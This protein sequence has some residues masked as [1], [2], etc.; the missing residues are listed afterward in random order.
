[1][2]TTKG[3]SNKF[4]DHSDYVM[5]IQSLV[6]ELKRPI[7]ACWVKGTPRRGSS[8]QRTI[9]RGSTERRCGQTGHATIENIHLNPPMRNIDHI[10]CQK[11]SLTINGQRYPLNWDT[12]VRW[13]INGTYLKQYLTTKH[14]WSEKTWRLI[15]PRLVK[16]YHNHKMIL[17]R[18]MWFKVAH[19]L[20][21]LGARKQKM[22]TNTCPNINIDTCPCCQKQPETQAT[23]HVHMRIQSE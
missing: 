22:H 15:D 3:K 19:N 1:M 16:A 6:E 20:H 21:T 12:T 13:T 18:N 5:T 23:P 11:I 7:A 8:L 14:N 4:P 9:K 10:A 17:A 2:Y